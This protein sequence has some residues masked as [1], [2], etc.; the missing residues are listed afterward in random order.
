MVLEE[1]TTASQSFDDNAPFS[2]SDPY[3]SKSRDPHN[4]LAIYPLSTSPTQI[5]IP[6]LNPLGRVLFSERRYHEH[7]GKHL[8]LQ[9]SAWSAV[10]ERHLTQEETDFATSNVARA[11]YVN[12]VGWATG[13]AVGVSQFRL[14]KELR[15]PKGL[16][17][18]NYA[19]MLFHNIQTHPPAAVF[20]AARNFFIFSAW[21]VGIAYLTGI[22][23]NVV[24]LSAE[25]SDP[26]LEDYRNSV[27]SRGS[28][29]TA[30][31]EAAAKKRT[32]DVWRKEYYLRNDQRQGKVRGD[33]D[34]T[35]PTGA[36]TNDYS[37]SGDR[38]VGNDTNSASYGVARGST[39]TNLGIYGDSQAR[40]SGVQQEFSNPPYSSNNNTSSGTDFFDDASPT[41]QDSG[42]YGG[43][44]SGSAWA[45]I[46]Q[47]AGRPGTNSGVS[48]RR[49]SGQQQEEY[50]TQYDSSPSSSTGSSFYGSRT[51][52]D[53]QYS[54]SDRDKQIAKEQAQKEFDRMVDA[55]RMGSDPSG[56]QTAGRG[57][58]WFRRQ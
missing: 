17:M 33:H 45:R 18:G 25:L 56:G 42:S 52:R 50:K 8:A 48:P 57:G 26:R 43:S 46:R 16:S 22:Y 34:N 53:F 12:E 30:R 2:D 14:T 28:G 24:R 35:S 51:D 58:G 9:M 27:R 3:A 40:Q 21:A 6:P 10:M 4:V 39:T 23:S 11:V 32:Q 29:E 31:V 15:P 36:E 47:S 1:G 37:Y 19:R 13:M 54:E 44:S 55:E 38:P 20:S 41:A 7:V 5:N 49:P